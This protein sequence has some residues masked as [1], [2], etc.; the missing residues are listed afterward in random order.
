MPEWRK[1]VRIIALVLLLAAS[2]FAQKDS[3]AVA[4]ACGPKNETFEVKRDETQHTIAH[5]EPGKARVYF[6]QDIGEV[7]CLGGC[8]TTKMGLDG[9]WVGANQHNSYFSV[10]V[11]AGEHHLCAN[12]Q[13]HVGWIGRMVALKHFTAEVGE[14]YYFRT[15]VIGSTSQELFDL[16]P[17]DSDQAKYLIASYPL[18]VSHPKQ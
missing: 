10:S 17:I 8:W 3:A 2:A 18:S 11:E 13:S 1:A 5:P 16:D 6:V 14:V 15:R 7:K 4:A 12:L 9:A